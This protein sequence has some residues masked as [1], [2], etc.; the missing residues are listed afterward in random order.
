MSFKSIMAGCAFALLLAACATAPAKFND[1]ILTNTAGM[2]LYNFDKDIADS[3]KSV[4]N[5]QC[6]KNWPP[7]MVTADDKPGDYWSI[8]TRDEG[9]KQWA[10]KG[11]PVYLWVK[12]QRP[13]DR[14]GDGFANAWRV[15]AADPPRAVMSY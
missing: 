9:G 5:G 3:G 6:A 14:T 10:Y 12:D 11:K 1:G 4:C 13:G 15:I 7:F 8:I 2:T